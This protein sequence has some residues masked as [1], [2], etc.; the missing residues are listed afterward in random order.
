MWQINY[1]QNL[2]IVHR[3]LKSIVL[4]EWLDNVAALNDLKDWIGMN[5]NQGEDV[6]EKVG[7]SRL[8]SDDFL[9]NFGIT[10]ILIFAVLLVI[11]LVATIIRVTLFR[12]NST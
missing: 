4:G 11:I 7:V 3:E 9:S 8:G 5:R 10:F 2:I 1:S 6:V 12:G